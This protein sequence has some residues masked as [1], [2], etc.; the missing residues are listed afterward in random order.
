MTAYMQLWSWGKL[1][2]LAEI[3][4]Y[5][6]AAFC[7]NASLEFSFVLIPTDA[8]LRDLPSLHWR[9]GKKKPVSYS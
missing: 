6:K 3:L 5:N 4:A 7:H 1:I 8:W 9:F 2:L